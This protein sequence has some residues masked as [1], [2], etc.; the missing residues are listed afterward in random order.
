MANNTVMNDD[1]EYYEK[2]EEKLA[3]MRLGDKQRINKKS[4]SFM[5]SA[6]G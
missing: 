5:E 1:A 6:S 3:R 2:L 4:M